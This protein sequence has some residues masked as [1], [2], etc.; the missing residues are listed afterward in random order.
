MQ[1]LCHNLKYRT[2]EAQFLNLYKKIIRH[3]SM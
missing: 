2:V 1:A 3:I